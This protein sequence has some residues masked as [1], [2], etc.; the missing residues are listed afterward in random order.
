MFKSNLSLVRLS[1]KQKTMWKEVIDRLGIK[2]LKIIFTLLK[3]LINFL[4]IA[5]LILWESDEP[6]S[7]LPNE[8]IFYNLTPL[9]YNIKVMKKRTTFPLRRN[10]ISW[11]RF[12]LNSFWQLLS[13]SSLIL[14]SKNNIMNTSNFSLFSLW[15]YLIERYLD[16]TD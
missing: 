5:N 11:F 10:F 16:G 8:R 1:I 7:V 14:N 13:C 9:S 4:S 2:H 6:N 15:K 12:F 3:V